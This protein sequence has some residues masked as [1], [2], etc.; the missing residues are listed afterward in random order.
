RGSGRA[1]RE[2]GWVLVE[3]IALMAVLLVGMTA[4]VI[5]VSS[6]LRALHAQRT[7]TTRLIEEEN[8]KAIEHT[9]DITADQSFE[10]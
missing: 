2:S 6:G 1:N 7:F 8:D 9:S 10:P 5:E 4:V 3:A